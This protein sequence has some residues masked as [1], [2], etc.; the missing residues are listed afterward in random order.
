MCLMM[1]TYATMQLLVSDH[2]HLFRSTRDEED[3][4]GVETRLLNFFNY[5]CTVPKPGPSWADLVAS[6]FN[7]SPTETLK[8]MNL[9]EWKQDHTH[10]RCW[11]R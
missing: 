5:P 10:F 7:V 6:L 3:G 2:P 9:Q 4:R 8:N 11:S 1:P